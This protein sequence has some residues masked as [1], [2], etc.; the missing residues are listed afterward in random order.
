M[1]P[2]KASLFLSVAVVCLA[3]APAVSAATLSGQ[4]S[5]A[6][7]GTMEGVLVTAKQDGSNI[8]VTV[9]SD[10]KGHYSFPEGRLTPGHY[11]IKIRAIGYI[12]DGPRAVDVAANGTRADVKLNTKRDRA[13]DLRCRARWRATPNW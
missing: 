11:N 5:S 13:S 3:S 10:D 12:L 2:P 9:V 1:N 7:E 4:I 6:K 8:S